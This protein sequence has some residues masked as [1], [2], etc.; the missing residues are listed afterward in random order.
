MHG[1]ATSGDI[2]CALIVWI[3]F[4]TSI[5]PKSKWKLEFFLGQIPFSILVLKSLSDRKEAN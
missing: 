1:E 2:G 4:L 5:F 3:P